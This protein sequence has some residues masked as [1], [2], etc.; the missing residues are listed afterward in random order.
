MIQVEAHGLLNRFSP[1]LVYTHGQP[2]CGDGLV[3]R[4]EDCD[5]GNLLDGDGCSKKCLLETGFN[6]KGEP[7]SVALVKNGSHP[8]PV[9]TVK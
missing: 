5:D 6:C 7:A 8:E 1:P 2:Y 4:S 3:Q 9:S